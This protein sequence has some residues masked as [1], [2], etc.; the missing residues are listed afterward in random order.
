VVQ[1]KPGKCQQSDGNGGVLVLAPIGRDASLAV[2][3]LQRSGIRAEI[4]NDL[5]DLTRRFSD[6]TNALL[7]A[8]EALVPRQLPALLQRLGEQPPWSDIPVIILSAPGGGDR[9]SIHALEIFGPAANVSLLERPLRTVTLVAATTVALRARRRQREVRN[10]LAERESALATVSRARIQAEEANRAKDQFLAM[11]SHELRTPLTPVLMMV[12]ML[13]QDRRLPEDVVS[14]IETVRRNIELEARLIDDLLDLTRITNSKLEL[15]L[16]VMDINASLE[17]A[18]GVSANEL[19]EK[20]IAVSKDL[21][22][23][24]HYALA[25]ASRL[26][27]VFWNIIKNAVKFTPAGGELLIKTRNKGEDILIEFTD[28]GMGIES[29]LLPRIFDAF[30]QGGRTMT[31]LYGGLGLGLAICKRLID[32]H[33]GQL[34]VYSDG[35]DTGATFTI[36]L[37]TMKRSEVGALVPPSN[38]APKSQPADI[39]LVEDHADSAEIMRRMLEKAGYRIH[40]AA[41][42][43]KAKELAAKEH[44]QLVISDLGLPDGDGLQLMR[45]LRQLRP[46]KGIALSGFGMESDV[47]ATRIAGFAEHLTK[48][49]NWG[50]LQ[51]AIERILR[52]QT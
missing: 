14:D 17:H 20:R 2:G 21:R 4:A 11:L 32:L 44:F 26:Q 5:L 9:A 19:V 45:D 28:T 37:K 47:A 6:E 10:L 38:H 36:V 16:S 48:P 42:V 39:L 24:K 7:I 15:S 41:T 25:D 30:E 1:A 35:P 51:E 27:Q 29:E 18:L 33:H 49:V 23:K 52:P 40:H 13:Q 8:E 46:L 22:A 50:Q 31:N 34:S 12:G 3:A 43:A